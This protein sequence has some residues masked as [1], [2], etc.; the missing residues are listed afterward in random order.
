MDQDKS[1]AISLRERGQFLLLLFAAA[2]GVYTF[3]QKEVIEPKSVPINVSVTLEARQGGP[4]P[5]GISK[6]ESHLVALEIKATARNP[7]TRTVYLLKTIW[8]ATASTVVQRKVPDTISKEIQDMLGS[9][10]LGQTEAFA[11][12][13]NGGLVAIGSLFE[14][15]VLKPNELISRTIVFYVPRGV[16]DQVRVVTDIPTVSKP[17]YVLERSF[18]NGDFGESKL[19]RVPDTVPGAP[20][21]KKVAAKREPVQMNGEL[22]VDQSIEFQRASSSADISLWIQPTAL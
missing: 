3:I 1:I 11:R 19:Y 7:S 10:Q 22:V 17:G 12:Y 15:S 21:G 5:T 20:P 18:E 2:W 9:D 6:A 8:Y 14:D 13:D 4:N 16:Y